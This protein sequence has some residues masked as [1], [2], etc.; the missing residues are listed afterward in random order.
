MPSEAN[1]HVE[2]PPQ[3]A[4]QPPGHAEPGQPPAEPEPGQ[5]PA[6]REPGR[7]PAARTESHPPA[8]RAPA[9]PASARPAPPPD[10]TPRASDA[11][12]NHALDRLRAAYVEGRLDQE[13]F[14]ER[15][16]AA[17]KAKTVGQLERLFD[18]LPASYTQGGLAHQLG[19]PGPVVRPG[20]GGT[21][22]SV[23]VMSGV[24]RRGR[25]RVPVDSTAFAFMGGVDLDLRSAIL[26]GPVTTITAVAI[27]GGVEVIVPPGVHVEMHGLPL[28]GGWSNHVREED[29]PPHAP[30][31]H[32]RGFALMGG[33]EVRTK[34][35]KP[36]D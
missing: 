1:D 20:E 16:D 14:D 34:K 24:E 33:V 29:L 28:L 36:K 11:E 5:L 8:E 9:E 15:S 17:F 26:S 35:P 31:V 22:L 30:E 27:M 7:P 18:D 10:T 4:T 3:P 13:E 6:T 19:G 2:Q 32:V 21:R 25:W 12:R 23:A